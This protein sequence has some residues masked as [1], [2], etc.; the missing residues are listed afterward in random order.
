MNL[1]EC[2]KGGGLQ[3]LYD[4]ADHHVESARSNPILRNCGRAKESADEQGC[5]MRV[6]LTQQLTAKLMRGE[7]ADAAQKCKGE[8]EGGEHIGGV[9]Q[10]EAGARWGDQAAAYQLH[11]PNAT[12]VG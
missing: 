11:H 10:D 4:H 5:N 9:P 8:G 1:S 7:T 6:R 3:R 2:G 12:T